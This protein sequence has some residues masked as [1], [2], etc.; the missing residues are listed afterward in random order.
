MKTATSYI[1]YRVQSGCSEITILYSLYTLYF[2]PAG[3]R[4]LSQN[5]EESKSQKLSRAEQIT[6][7]WGK[8]CKNNRVYTFQSKSNLPPP[9]HCLL[10]E[11]GLRTWIWSSW[12]RL[13]VIFL[14]PEIISY[15]TS[16]FYH[17]IINFCHSFNKYLFSKAICQRHKGKET[18]SLLQRWQSNREN[19]PIIRQLHD[20][21]ITFLLSTALDSSALPGSLSV[22][23]GHGIAGV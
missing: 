17:N 3:P 1:I 22:C 9:S 21:V 10:H 18:K 11:F 2:S 5:T 4:V 23:T 20:N 15:L 12:I 19:R 14:G 6:E 7:M 8:G 16:S 13:T